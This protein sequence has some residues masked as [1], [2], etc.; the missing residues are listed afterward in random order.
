MTTTAAAQDEPFGLALPIPDGADT[1]HLAAALI[2]PRSWRFGEPHVADQW[3]PAIG[4]Y[5]PENRLFS[6][7]LPCLFVDGRTVVLVEDPNFEP[8]SL[9]DTETSNAGPQLRLAKDQD[10]DFRVTCQFTDCTSED[11][12]TAN[13]LHQDIHD[14]YISRGYTGFALNRHARKVTLLGIIK[15]DTGGEHYRDIFLQDG[16]KETCNGGHP[17]E[18]KS[19]S[20]TVIICYKRGDDAWLRSLVRHEM[21]HAVQHFPPAFLHDALYVKS[22][23]GTPLTLD[24]QAAIED[25]RWI[26]EGTASAAS[27]SGDTMKRRIIND[28]PL[29][30]INVALT[31]SEL[32]DGS[33]EKSHIEYQT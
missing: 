5:D 22:L 9:P 8:L 12:I 18:Y 2:G 16:S 19:D 31:A 10:S 17:A 26:S 4:Y 15:I 23:E 25:F 7:D 6:V 28:R 24:A 33:D 3:L 32:F 30:P 29:H 13:K 1:A 27:D 21:F 14:E 20:C 11:Q